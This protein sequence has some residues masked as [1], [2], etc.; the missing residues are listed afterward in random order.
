V[1]GQNAMVEVDLPIALLRA[2]RHALLGWLCDLLLRFSLDSLSRGESSRPSAVLLVCVTTCW[3]ISGARPR[4]S[5]QYCCLCLLSCPVLCCLCL[6][7]IPAVLLPCRP[8]SHARIQ[9][10]TIPPSSLQANRHIAHQNST[11]DEHSLG[12]HQGRRQ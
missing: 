8:F 1:K 9:H 5:Y 2:H 10:S 11:Q 7:I 6:C 3:S 12:L 4:R